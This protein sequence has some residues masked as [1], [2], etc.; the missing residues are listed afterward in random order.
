MPGKGWASELLGLAGDGY[1]EESEVSLPGEEPRIQ[2]WT[3]SDPSSCALSGQ[4]R[5]WTLELDKLGLPPWS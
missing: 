5:A 1:C 3:A 2:A 4:L